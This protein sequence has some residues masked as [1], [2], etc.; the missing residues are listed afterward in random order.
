MTGGGIP[1]RAAERK[2][3]GLARPRTAA[4]DLKRAVA[5]GARRAVGKGGL[6]ARALQSSVY[7]VALPSPANV[8][9]IGFW[10]PTRPFASETQPFPLGQGS[11]RRR[12]GRAAARRS[13]PGPEAD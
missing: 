2:D 6:I 12:R 8:P 9:S 10:N 5:G 13:R 1:A 4:H 3:K 7:S 11:R